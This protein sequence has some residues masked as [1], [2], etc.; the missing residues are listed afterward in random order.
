MGRD[1]RQEG[2]VDECGLVWGS[3]GAEV[4]MIVRSDSTELDMVVLRAGRALY[5]VLG[6]ADPVGEGL[7]PPSS[8]AVLS[9]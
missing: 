3:V 6:P 5:C 2:S 8:A 4:S 1:Q 9:N 7:I